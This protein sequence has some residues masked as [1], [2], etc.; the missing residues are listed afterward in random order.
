ML[1]LRD[2]VG[3]QRFNTISRSLGD[4]RKKAIDSLVETAEKLHLSGGSDVGPYRPSLIKSQ[5]GYDRCW[6]NRI[7]ASVHVSRFPANAAATFEETFSDAIGVGVVWLIATPSEV[8]L[9]PIPNR[10][11]R[12]SILHD[13]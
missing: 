6:K 9:I 10:H 12:P 4:D 2:H 8:T 1:A 13:I 3:K 7:G 11:Q 5:A